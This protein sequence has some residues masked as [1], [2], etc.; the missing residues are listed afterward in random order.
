MS[1]QMFD[2]PPELSIVVP[3]LNEAAGIVGHWRRWRRCG[4]AAPK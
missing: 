4:G 3:A 2:A 1:R